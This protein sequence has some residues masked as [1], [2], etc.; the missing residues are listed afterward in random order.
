MSEAL[1]QKFSDQPNVFT[2]RITEKIYPEFEN[3]QR[4]AGISRN[5][6]INEAVADLLAAKKQK[7]EIE[8]APA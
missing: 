8:K 5:R 3:I 7:L 2:I 6:L 1:K 4:A